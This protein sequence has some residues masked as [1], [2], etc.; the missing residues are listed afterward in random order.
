MLATCL[1]PR[2]RYG[3]ATALPL[4]LLRGHIGASPLERVLPV[5]DGA[6]RPDEDPRAGWG[7]AGLVEVKVRDLTP[8]PHR[9][10]RPKRTRLLRRADMPR[11]HHRTLEATRC[12]LS[13]FP[14]QFPGIEAVVAGDVATP[15]LGQSWLR[16][17]RSATT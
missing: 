17:R 12:T 6:P 13:G 5:V 4:L 15:G 2:W 7:L 14:L 1:L 8:A 16:K 3:A 9:L 10:V 11:R